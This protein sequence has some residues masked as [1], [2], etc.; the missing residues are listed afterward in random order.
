MYFRKIDILEIHFTDYIIYLFIC[1]L[2][3]ADKTV[4]KIQKEKNSGGDSS[5]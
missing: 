4:K 3:Y 5:P 1:N 2:I